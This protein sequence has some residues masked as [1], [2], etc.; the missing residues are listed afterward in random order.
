MKKTS[1]LFYLFVFCFHINLFAQGQ[2]PKREFRGAWIATVINLDWPSTR[3]LSEAQQRTELL[4]I[5]DE[6]HEAG[7][8][9]VFLQIRPESDA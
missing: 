5:F 2:P 6:L 7:I 8:N 1:R 9:A 4:R 3:N